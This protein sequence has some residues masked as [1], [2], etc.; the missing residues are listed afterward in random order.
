MRAAPPTAPS[1]G[2]AL[3]GRVRITIAGGAV[4]FRERSFA[5]GAVA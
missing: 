2:A 1:P 3:T 5:I 4:A